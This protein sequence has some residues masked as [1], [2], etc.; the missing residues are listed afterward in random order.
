[1]TESTNAQD[2]RQ[3]LRVEA[4]G[5]ALLYEKVEQGDLQPIRDEIVSRVSAQQDLEIETE[6]L[7]HSG[8]LREN[9]NEQFAQFGRFLSQLDAKLDYLVSLAEGTAPVGTL[10]HP[11]SLLDISAAGLSFFCEESMGN[12]QYL[13]VRLQISRFPLNEIWSLCHVVWSQ[14][15]DRKT[16]N[17]T[18]E[19]GLHFDTI[20]ED[21]RE[22]IFRFISRME[23][24]MLRERKEAKT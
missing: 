21:D 12:D 1:M 18:F 2:R 6:R 16:Q 23:R 11:V 5:L 20:S 4:S 15:S 17:P 8:D 24:K 19:I 10:P 9:I 14:P 13:K 7:W 3:Y 22:R